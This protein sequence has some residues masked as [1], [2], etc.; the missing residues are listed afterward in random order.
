VSLVDRAHAIA[1]I[2]A[3]ARRSSR[4]ERAR[5]QQATAAPAPTPA[6]GTTAPSVASLERFSASSLQVAAARDGA[7]G[8]AALPA[9]SRPVSERRPAPRKLCAW[10]RRNS[11]QLGPIR[12]GAGPR[13]ATRKTVAI[14]VAENADPELQ[15]LALDAHR[16]PASVLPPQPEDQA[17]HRGRKRR[18]TRRAGAPS[19]IA[20]QQRPVPAAQR[21]RAG[22]KTRPALERKQPTCR[23]K[24]RTVSGRVLRPPPFRAS[25]SPLGS[26]EPRSRARAHRQRGRADERKRKG[27]GTANRSARR[28]VWTTPTMIVS[29]TVQTESSFFTPQGCPGSRGNTG[30]PRT[31]SS[32]QRSSPPTA[33][34]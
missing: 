10:A 6:V 25:R 19:A 3:A 5:R 11:D 17:G 32:A 31:R 2:N 4:R 15:Q 33:A 21:L 24:Q 7:L 18:T 20:L 9:R 14:V 27:A 13:P 16:A 28:A 12:R 26:P 34:R 8:A 22:R 23:S 29:T 1:A 30:S